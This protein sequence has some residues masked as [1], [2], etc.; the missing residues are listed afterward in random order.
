MP[1]RGR[2]DVN[3]VTPQEAT[4]FLHRFAGLPS[5]ALTV[6]GFAIGVVIP[7]AAS[8]KVPL[9]G[10]CSI[11]EWQAR[12]NHLSAWREPSPTGVGRAAVA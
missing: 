2:D 10:Y 5:D 11:V 3:A 7:Q 6:A 4:G 9:D 8:G 12:L 1:A